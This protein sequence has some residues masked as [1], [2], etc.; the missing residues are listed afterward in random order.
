MKIEIHPE[1]YQNFNKQIAEL[2]NLLELR[3]YEK[4]IKK[5][6][7]ED[8][9]TQIID[10]KEIIGDVIT[11]KVMDDLTEVS[12]SYI[13]EKGYRGLFDATYK[14][15]QTICESLQKLNALRNTISLEC[16]KELIFRWLKEKDKKNIS[17]SP[18][19][20]LIA[21]CEKKIKSWTI[22]L[23][24][25]EL[26]IE[27][28]FDLGKVKIRTLTKDMIDN[29]KSSIEK[30][31]VRK[32]NNN[33]ENSSKYFED[34]LKNFGGKA[35]AE[36]DVEAEF[37]MAID[38]AQEESSKALSILRFYSRANLTPNLI[39]CCVIVGSENLKVVNYLFLEDHL[40]IKS[41]SR[42]DGNYLRNWVIR[43]ED[44]ELYLNMGLRQLNYL[45]AQDN[46]NDFQE[47][48]LDSIL[49][50]SR[51]SL[52]QNVHDK[53]IYI[54]ASLESMLLLNDNES[55]QQ[56]L[57]ERIAILIGKTV[58]NKI[59]IKKNVKYIYGL[60]SK[61]I[62]HGR[63]LETSQNEEIKKFLMNVFLL[64]SQL[65]ANLSFFKSK[66]DLVEF[67]EVKKFS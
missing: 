55:I 20:F 42:I 29:W 11:K 46:L 4:D 35:I 6:Q 3:P 12:I 5:F 38:I 2:E 43:N 61:F 30:L 56:N 65:I 7:P 22:L 25:S 44:L 48:L 9:N 24:I 17:N 52:M 63:K 27:T 62:H 59:D 10:G 45:I 51:N 47:Q 21:E 19:E 36:I 8:F 66:E 26:A 54:L 50:Y 1:A 32:E 33:K 37:E 28:E 64:F 67:I 41:Y 57:S 14:Q 58:D 49:I 15:Y 53:I 34:I 39:S 60:R 16:T 23:P 40:L 31:K 13:T 18:L